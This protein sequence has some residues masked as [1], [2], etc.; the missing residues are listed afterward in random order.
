MAVDA[1]SFVSMRRARIGLAFTFDDHFAAA[2]AKRDR[3]AWRACQT[4]S[5]TRTPMLD[6]LAEV[7]SSGRP[8]ASLPPASAAQSRRSPDEVHRDAD[9]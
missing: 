3:R 2:P 6:V 5:G 1:A 4:R 8:C 7:L 9:P